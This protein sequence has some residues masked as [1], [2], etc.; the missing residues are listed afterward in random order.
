MLT[1]GK[2]WSNTRL[3]VMLKNDASDEAEN[4]RADLSKYLTDVQTILKAAGTQPKDF[5]LHDEAHAFRVA[6]RMV[7]V[8]GAQQIV[9]LSVYEK[10]QLLLSA[11]L[12]DI[13]MAP[14]QKRVGALHH[15][16]ICKEALDPDPLGGD[17]T[18]SFRTFL[19]DNDVAHW[20]LCDGNPT[21]KDLARAAWLVSHFCRTRHNDWGGAFIER[22]FE[23]KKLGSY[24]GWVS[25]LK[26]LCMSHH[27]GLEKLKNDTFKAKNVRDQTVNLRFLAAVLRVA[28]VMEVDPD[29]T[30]DVILTH[31]AVVADSIAHWLKD[32][33]MSVNILPQGGG[34]D[35]LLR[36]DISATPGAAYV[37]KAV[38]DTAGYIND[39]LR[40]CR[41][42]AD[43]N[44]FLDGVHKATEH[45]RYQ[46][47]L[48]GQAH[49]DIRPDGDQYVYINGTF[50]PNTQKVLQLL[51]GIELY[52]DSRVAV[53]EML[54]NAFDA[55]RWEIAERRLKHPSG[56]DTQTA[57][58]LGVEFL[59][60]LAIEKH[61]D[62]LI[63]VCEDNGLG[64]SQTI[65]MDRF[66]VSGASGGARI[67]DL[68]DRCKKQGFSS[69]ITG[70]FGIGVLS[71]FMLGDRLKVRTRA[72]VA[73]ATEESGWCFETGGIGDFGE[74]RADDT[75]KPGTELHLTLRK[76]LWAKEDDAKSWVQ[77]LFQNIGKTLVRLPCRV[78]IDFTAVDADLRLEAQPGWR[79]D[80]AEM[81][82]K[83]LAHFVPEDRHSRGNE[84]N[85]RTA[86]ELEELSGEEV[87]WTTQRAR[88]KEAL[89][90]H[91]I[92]GE[93]ADGAIKYHLS[94]PYFALPDGGCLA[95]LVEVDGEL[96]LV[97][98]CPHEVISW[99]G[100]ATRLER[101]VFYFGI[102]EQIIDFP[103][104]AQFDVLD[105]TFG[106]LNVNRNEMTVDDAAW[107]EVR[108]ALISRIETE[109]Q[110]LMVGDL[111]GP[112]A[113]INFAL[114]MESE[115]WYQQKPLTFKGDARWY[116][117]ERTEHVA[118]RP[119][120]F[121]QWRGGVPPN[122]FPPSQSAFVKAEH[123]IYEMFLGRGVVPQRIRHSVYHFRD[124][125]V[126]TAF[127]A[128]WGDE[129]HFCATSEI[130]ACTFP[131]DWADVLYV[132]T[133]GLG[134]VFNADHVLTALLQAWPD[135]AAWSAG[136]KQDLEDTAQLRADVFDTANKAAWWLA[137]SLRQQPKTFW[138][139]LTERDPAFLSDLFV[140]LKLNED[141]VVVDSR[142]HRSRLQEHFIL[143]PQGL[144]ITR[145]PLPWPQAAEWRVDFTDGAY[146]RHLKAQEAKAKAGKPGRKKKAPVKGKRT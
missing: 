61:D 37:E 41:G 58:N 12:H 25:D 99:K 146:E 89:R 94:L 104:Y 86:A 44:A 68:E 57:L 124:Q 56:K 40:L 35:A 78:D 83:C 80:Q 71:Y 33:V 4:V 88:A 38:R 63:L 45:G 36:V 22:T 16:L 10:A 39:E 70:Q 103:G 66:L 84:D 95:Q 46:W 53:R 18:R 34:A 75:M 42:L 65:L 93:L 116:W 76:A 105:A 108:K 15:L 73:L 142:E 130:R 23:G 113:A 60:R 9:E 112:Y 137:M 125:K 127:I 5:T 131:P 51:S 28:D 82:E 119:F 123:G 101:E 145:D 100:M 129:F 133:R 52:G 20:P 118:A 120:L 143:S 110:T 140:F 79:I 135:G 136:L 43:D 121:R 132:A 2:D 6:E 138:A 29:R 49:E 8:V 102:E 64:M 27:Y 55:V 81:A 122:N 98:A 59:V 77:G 106:R 128:D 17:I 32:Q 14:E 72:S 85:Y 115:I 54:Q 87:F 1:T 90:W 107:A 24:S 96:Q 114:I 69:E 92:Q 26:V 31:R 3:W 11:Y 144:S 48:M 97:P 67:M 141:V 126:N 111:S 30:P 91:V 117:P 50:R 7:D 13:G 62:E 109:I 139:V 134:Q 19:F 74:L 21:A 47:R